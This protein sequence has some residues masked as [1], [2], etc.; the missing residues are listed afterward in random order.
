MDKNFQWTDESFAGEA[1][2]IITVISALGKEDILD[3]IPIL[4]LNI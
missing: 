2:V 3:K 4:L 1:S